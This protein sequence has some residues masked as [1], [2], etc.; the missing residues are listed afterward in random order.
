MLTLGL[1]DKST[2]KQKQVVLFR[3]V[4]ID[5]DGGFYIY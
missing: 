4:P 2:V 5:I 3:A 1:S